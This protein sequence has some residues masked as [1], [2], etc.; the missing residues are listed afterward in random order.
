MFASFFPSPR[1]FFGSAAL[2]ALAV[3]LFWFLVARDGGGM[4]GLANPPEGTPPII[5]VSRFFSAP[6]LWFYLY[7]GGAVAI[8]AGVWR[9]LDPHPYFNWSVLGSALIIFVLYFMVEVSVTINDW[10]GTYFDLI[11]RALDPST[12][13]QV[14]AA[15]L[16]TGLAQITSVLL[17]YITVAVLNAFFTSHYVFRWRTAMNS[18]YTARWNEL[19]GIEGAAQRVQEDT[20]RFARMFEDLGTSLIS[21]IMTL[22]AFLPILAALSG[23]IPEIPILGSIPYSLVWVSLL[24]SLFGT[25]LLALVGIRLPGLEFRNQR[26]EAA[27]RKELV[28]GEDDPT[29]AAPRTLKEL[30]E[31]VRHNY[32]R[33][34]FNYLY[35]NVVRYG[36]L[37]AD[38]LL[39]F[40]VLIPAIA[41]G[42]ITFGI[43]QQVRASFGEVRDAMQYLVKSW[44][45]IVEF[46][47]IYKRLRAFEATLAGQPLPDLDRRY[48]ERG[49][50]A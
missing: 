8:F 26:V 9:W 7:F 45:S 32:F 34:Y 43:F 36:Y 48:L 29:R 6:F 38:L 2:W 14:P 33:L 30:F 3:V 5:G 4:L 10:Y 44:P 12:K 35:F 39:P 11:Q 41:A 24:W 25:G 20:M 16:Y 17:T 31:G 46:L 49:Q 42:A 37:Q 27:Y 50:T 19:R 22:I 21:A 23:K 40:F 1:Q 18:F 28:Y 15:D 47:S 13:G